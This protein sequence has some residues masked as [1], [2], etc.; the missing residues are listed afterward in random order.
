[1]DKPA[2]VYVTFIK[3]TRERV[4]QA[5][6]DGAIIPEYWFGFRLESDWKVGGPLRF[7]SPDGKLAHDDRVLRYEPH[8]VI[9]YSWH[10]LMHGFDKEA[11]SR[12]TF[13]LEDA[14]GG[15]KLTLTH[16]Q[17][18]DE[19]IV[20]PAVSN[21]WPAVLSNLKTLLETGETLGIRPPN[22]IKK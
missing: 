22:K 1:M 12:V 7:Y 17:S 21:G 18:P 11:E 9:S 8:S 6:T 4:F 5:L 20:L 3:S 19:S 15:V 16:D 10:P 14:D 13:T 2:F